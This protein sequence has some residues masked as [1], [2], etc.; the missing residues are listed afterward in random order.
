[1]LGLVLC[2]THNIED[3]IVSLKQ[4]E[5]IY[6]KKAHVRYVY[7]YIYMNQAYEIHKEYDNALQYLIKVQKLAIKF[8]GKNSSIALAH[9]LCPIEQFPS[10]D[11]S[12]KNQNYYS[13]ALEIIRTLFGENHIR[14]ARYHF[15]LGQIYENLRDKNNAKQHYQEAL[16]IANKQHFN[17]EILIA[18]HRKNIAIIQDRL[19][20]L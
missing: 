15:L 19:K 8:W 14:T 11:K 9:Q 3:S 20:R 10:L 13:Q 1:M 16:D 4:A 18:G 6:C 5:I 7:L 2:A 17:S 12:E